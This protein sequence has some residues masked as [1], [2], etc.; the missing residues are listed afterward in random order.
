MNADGL[1]ILG[2]EDGSEF[3]ARFGGCCYLL[4]KSAVQPGTG[5]V[6]SAFSNGDFMIERLSFWTSW[7]PCRVLVC[8]VC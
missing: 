1:Q 8:V 5:M 6:L 4:Q 3:P 7:G 2:C